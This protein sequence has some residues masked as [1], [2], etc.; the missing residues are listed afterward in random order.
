MEP[1][2][3]DNSLITRDWRTGDMEAAFEATEMM[4]EGEVRSERITGVSIEP[5]GSVASYDAYR[6]KL[7]LWE[8]TQNPHPL[9]TFLAETLEIPE[10]SIQVIQPRVGGA[11]GAQTAAVSKEQPLIA[12]LARKL[13]RPI[14]WIEERYENFATTGHSRD[15]IFNYRA[16]FDREGIVSGLDIEVLAD[17]GA[18]TALLGWGQSFV[19]AYCLPT[20]YRVPEQPHSSQRGRHQQDALECVSRVREGLGDLPDGEDHGSRCPRAEDGSRR[21]PVQELH[22]ARRVSLLAAVGSHARQRRL[23]GLVGEGAG[24]GGMGGLRRVAASRP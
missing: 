15:V 3:G 11:F 7:T 12:Y 24:N 13:E 1:D 19:T 22:P 17:V 20:V 23:P 5:R 18:P 2:W 4:I 16:A 6:D 10:R 8:S 14:K 21:S 9:R